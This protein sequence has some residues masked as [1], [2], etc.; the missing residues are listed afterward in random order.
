MSLLR[1]LLVFAALAIAGCATVPGPSGGIS[2][3]EKARLY[4][5]RAEAIGQIDVWS[6]DGKLAVSNGEDGGSGR[7]QWNSAPG[8][9]E[10]DFRGALGRGAWRLDIRPGMA[11]LDLASGESWQ[12]AHVSTLVRDHVGW[13][14]PVDALAWWVRGLAAPGSV[15]G[16]QI[17]SDGRMT[18]L[19]QHGWEVEYKKYKVFSGTDMPIR[20][21]ARNGE[22]HVKF[23]MREWA[24]GE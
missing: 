23:I 2:D 22:H 18:L 21:D 10:L 11:Q 14:V 15:D 7:L 1:P 3:S 24:L 6:L 8:L 19:S 20:L 16:R 13:D 17:D 5:S 4:D 9:S 12:A